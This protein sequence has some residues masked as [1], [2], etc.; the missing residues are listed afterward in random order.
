M[1]MD[2]GRAL[3]KQ[4]LTESKGTVTPQVA[5]VIAAYAEAVRAGSVND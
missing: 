3:M 5:S 1:S 4:L 2:T